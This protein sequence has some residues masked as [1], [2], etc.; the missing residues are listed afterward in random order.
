MATDLLEADMIVAI[1]VQAAHM[2]ISLLYLQSLPMLEA[3]M[4][5]L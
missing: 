5:G 2:C 3:M 4:V 1:F